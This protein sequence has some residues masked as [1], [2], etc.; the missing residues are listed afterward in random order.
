MI[1]WGSKAREK[2]VKSG[3][4]FCPEC[5]TQRGYNHIRVSQYFTLYFIPLFATSFLGEYVRCGWCNSQ[6][7]P[8]VLDLSREQILAATAP[9]PCPSCNN[10]NPGNQRKCLSCGSQKPQ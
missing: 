1:I 5:Q 9:W 10:K 4:F 3:A 7:K 8:G 6:Y 2:T